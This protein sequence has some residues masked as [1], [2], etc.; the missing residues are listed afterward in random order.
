MIP[1]TVFDDAVIIAIGSVYAIA[2]W[3]VVAAYWR[4]QVRRI[5]EGRALGRGRPQSPLEQ[6]PGD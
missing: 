4:W 3:A 6:R 2:F 1:A 5:D